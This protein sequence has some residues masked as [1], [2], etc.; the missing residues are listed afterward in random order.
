MSYIELD[1]HPRF[2][3]GGQ[4]STPSKNQH[5]EEDLMDEEV[6]SATFDQEN[7]DTEETENED[8]A[9]ENN[10]EEDEETTE[11][12]DETGEEEMELE[13]DEDEQSS[14]RTGNHCVCML[15]SDNSRP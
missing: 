3:N 1:S 12:E 9:T 5:E 11:E 8:S 13:D 10:E 6:D 7:E 15:I 14:R 2:R 4:P